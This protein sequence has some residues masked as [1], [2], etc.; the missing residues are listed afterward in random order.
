MLK[1]SSIA[2]K[3]PPKSKAPKGHQ[4]SKGRRLGYRIMTHWQLYVFLALPLLYLIIF[5]Y[6]PMAGIQLAFKRFQGNLGIWGSPWVGLTY[7]KKFFGS[8]QFGRVISNTLL[9]SGYG[10]IAGFPM[11]II[12]ALALNAM[13][14]RRYKRFS[15]TV[16]Y[17][18]YFISTVVM[19]S[20]LVQVFNPRAGLLMNLVHLFNPSAELPNLIAS[21]KAVRHLYIWSGV[22]QSMGYNSIIYI[23]ALASVDPELHEA[24][25]IDGA[26]RFQRLWHIDFPTILPTASILLILNAGRI[27]SLGFEKI[28]LMQ[29]NLNISSTEV[30]ST[31]IYKIG[32]ANAL[33]DFS[34]GTAIGL[35][36]SVIN[37]ILIVAVNQ[38]SKRLG[39]QSLF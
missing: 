2:T 33:P 14:S 11:P 25:E 24:A 32:L 30:I 34:Y 15:Q 6:I 28:Y 4:V 17:L 26:N 37:L 7:F 36:N 3:S 23:A 39:G 27:M 10:L 18:P 12:L 13:R 19:V 29:N 5:Q 38:I 16:T 31:Y 9:L 21:P 8:Y 22:W 1:E 20:I 35:F